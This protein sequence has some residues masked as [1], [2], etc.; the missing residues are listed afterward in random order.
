[1]T[2]KQE[3][4]K[5]PIEQALKYIERIRNG[6]V[7]TETGRPIPQSDSIPAFC[8]VISDLTESIVERCKILGLRVTADK[9]GYFG[10]NDNYKAY[11][12]VL[13]FDQLLKMSRERNRAFF[14]KLGLPIN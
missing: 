4:K 7:L 13:S 11:I 10:Y 3:R 2:Q 14:D 8:Y 12:E 9:L 5:I 1:M 6:K